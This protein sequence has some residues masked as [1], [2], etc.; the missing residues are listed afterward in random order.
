MTD[1]FIPQMQSK[2][3]K[4]SKY[5]NKKV[6]YQGRTF[7]SI[8]ERDRYI[9]LQDAQRRGE[10]QNLRC[11]VSFD[12]DVNGEH[13]CKYVADFVYTK[14]YR[15][16]LGGHV[17]ESVVEDVKGMATAMFKLK[18]KLMRAVHGIDVRVVKSPTAVI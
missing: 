10:I 1:V 18:A 16:P 5:G 6:S 7:D 8:I 12:I 9:F 14:E 2:K 4:R 15:R 11:Q 13:C 3:K 17:Q